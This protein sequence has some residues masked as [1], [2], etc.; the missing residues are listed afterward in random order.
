MAFGDF[1]DLVFSTV[2]LTSRGGL[3]YNTT[4]G[5]GAGTTDAVMVL[6]FGLD[7]SKTAADLTITFPT[8]DA[9]NAIIRL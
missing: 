5:G 8:A 6:D 9:M 4:T 2:T 7:R 1:V 3:I